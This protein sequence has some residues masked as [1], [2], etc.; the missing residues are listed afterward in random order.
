[1]PTPKFKPGESGNPAGRPPGKTVGSLLRKAIESRSDEVV[2]VVVDAALNG[3]MAACKLLL[4]KIIPPLKA[5]AP[6]IELPGTTGLPLAEQGT[7][8][9][10]AALSGQIPG[11]LASQLVGALSAQA[12]IVETTEL[13]ARIEK[14]EAKQ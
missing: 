2:Q 11:D 1:M 13:V 5:T 6:S 7:C 12:K 8:V 3:D 14:L 9:I 4:D 10:S